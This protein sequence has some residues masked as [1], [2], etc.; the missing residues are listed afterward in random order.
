MGLGGDF[1]EEIL[2]T[3]R[4]LEEVGVILWYNRYNNCV[5][6]GLAQIITLGLFMAR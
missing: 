4:L 2:L 5:K 1:S 3:G 6:N